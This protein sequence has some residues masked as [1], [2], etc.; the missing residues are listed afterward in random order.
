MSSVISFGAPW[1][2]PLKV[3]TI[4]TVVLLTGIAITGLLTGPRGGKEGVIWLV[5]M[6][7]LPLLIW[8]FALPFAVCGY[9]L[10]RGTLLISRFGW[11]SRI[12][13]KGLKGAE[14]DPKAMA[15]SIR[16]FGNGG[17][18]SFTGLYWSRKLGSYR[19]YVTDFRFCVI[20]RFNRGVVVVS[21]DDPEAFVRDLKMLKGI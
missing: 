20:L 11:Y 13:L 4:L 18:F 15:G 19:A 12:D 3:A 6:V 17:L 10:S 2:K 1:G 14:V 5:A 8:V 21:P 7:V 16:T 9:V